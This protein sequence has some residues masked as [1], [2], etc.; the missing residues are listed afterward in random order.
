MKLIRLSTDCHDLKR[1][2]TIYATDRGTFVF[3][4][5]IVIDGEALVAM[6]LSSEEGAVE[7]PE[8]LVRKVWGDAD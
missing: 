4:G 5:Y 1:C 7:I 2:P 6:N 3:Q 8:A